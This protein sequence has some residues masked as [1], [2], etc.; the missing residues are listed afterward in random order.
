MR[1]LNLDLA[2]ATKQIVNSIHSYARD[3]D[4]SA[5]TLRSGVTPPPGN[6]TTEQ[7]DRLIAAYQAL[8]TCVLTFSVQSPRYGILC[9]RQE[10]HSALPYDDIIPASFN[11]VAHPVRPQFHSA[12]DAGPGPRDGAMHVKCQVSAASPEANLHGAVK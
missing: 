3:F 5:C 12:V 7:A 9:D 1:S 8:V 2:S 10:D 4:R 11:R 6:D